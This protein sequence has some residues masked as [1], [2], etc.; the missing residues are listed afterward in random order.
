MVKALRQGW[1]LPQE[2]AAL[3]AETA[4]ATLDQGIDFYR[5]S[6]EFFKA[7]SE[8]E[9][10]DFTR[11]LFTVAASDGQLSHDEIETIRSIA[12]VL[13]LTHKQFIEAKIQTKG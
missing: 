7:T 9:R 12:Q 11:A 6:R 1:N 13:K 8:T 3:V 2:A 10:L 5:I 4:L